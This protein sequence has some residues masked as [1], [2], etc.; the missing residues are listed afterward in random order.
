M[1][2]D[3]LIVILMFASMVA[4]AA[5]IL[6]VKDRWVARLRR[7]SGR[8]EGNGRPWYEPVRTIFGAFVFG[9]F[10]VAALGILVRVLLGMPVSDGA[11]GFLK[12]V[13]ASAA[14]SIGLFSLTFL[15]DYIKSYDR[16]VNASIALVQQ[17]EAERAIAELRA[18]I[19]TKGPSAKRLNGIGLLHALRESW[20]EALAAFDEAIRLG[21]RRPDLLGNQA[22]ALWKLGRVEEAEAILSEAIGKNRRANARV[23]QILV[24]QGF[25]I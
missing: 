15:Y 17:G 2:I 11:M 6:L 23:S 8:K 10:L 9:T 18:I 3:V 24:L 5:L 22:V 14:F 20:G 16:D 13:G 25:A 19:E 21:G 1:N 4:A 7:K 12:A